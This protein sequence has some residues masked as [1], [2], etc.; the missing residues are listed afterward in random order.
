MICVDNWTFC[1]KLELI[2][3]GVFLCGCVKEVEM[4]SFQRLA[5]RV[6][7]TQMPIMVKV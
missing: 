3:S 5:T 7:E 6:V 1:Y 4:G 2:L